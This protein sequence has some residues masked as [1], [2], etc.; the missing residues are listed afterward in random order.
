[1]AT[2]ETFPRFTSPGTGNLERNLAISVIRLRTTET[3]TQ[4]VVVI[5][6]VL[7]RIGQRQ[8][9]ADSV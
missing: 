9:G 2:I 8:F 6:V 5:V 1:M 4:W 3:L 7:D